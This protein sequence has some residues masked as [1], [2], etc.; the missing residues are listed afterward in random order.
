M[1]NYT[2]FNSIQEY[3]MNYLIALRRKRILACEL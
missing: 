3:S 1:Q 2:A